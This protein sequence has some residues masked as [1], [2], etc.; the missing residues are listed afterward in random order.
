MMQA[1]EV[2]K[3]A[4]FTSPHY[5]YLRDHQI[6]LIIPLQQ[7]CVLSQWNLFYPLLWFGECA[8]KNLVT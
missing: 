4:V 5:T 3:D 2:D 1:A 7:E 6:D 8:L